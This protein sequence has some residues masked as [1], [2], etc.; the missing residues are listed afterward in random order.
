MDCVPRTTKAQK[1]DSLS[2]MANIAGYRAVIEAFQ[3]FKRC[4]KPMV[5]AAGKLPPAEV[6]VIGAGVAG[7]SAI[8]YCRS[9]GCIVRAM[10]TRPAAREDAESMG[11]EFLAVNSQ[12]DGT[13]A[14]GYAKEMSEEFQAAQRQLTFKAA[15]RSDIV[16]T[17]ALVPGKP[18]PKLLTDEVVWAMKNGSV[19]VDMAAE[20]GGNCSLTTAGQVIV[21]QNGVTVV[22]LTDLV[23]RMAPQASELYANNMWNLLEEM[24]GG[25]DFKVDLEHEVIKRIAIVHG[26]RFFW[27]KPEIAPPPAAKAKTLEQHPL[28]TKPKSRSCFRK[29]EW[30]FVTII[31]VCV[32]LGLRYSTS[33]EFLDLFFIFILAIFIGYMVI[34]DVAPA[35]HTPLMSVTNAISGIIIIGAMMTLQP[36]EGFLDEGSTIGLVAVFFA[37]I[38]IWGGF[39]VTQ[40]ML[41]MFKS[42]S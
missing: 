37:S 3:H 13:G 19:I 9:L 4:P 42:S 22:G 35:L 8:G 34:W 25:K 40:R 41:S 31:L 17:T 18:A 20:M 7:L 39:I 6:L 28:H 2:S 32:F 1:L 23:S 29:V 11:A 33:T 26:G 5:T 36:N 14:G 27:N 10:D 15:R 24:G 16:I 21:T 30:P 38:N 12:E